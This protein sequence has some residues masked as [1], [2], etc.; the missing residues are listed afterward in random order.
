MCVFDLQRIIATT[1][2]SQVDFHASLKS[3]NDR[4]LELIKTGDDF[5]LLVLTNQQSAGRGQGNRNWVAGTGSLTFTLC[6]PGS[7]LAMPES[8]ALLLPLTVGL[9][10]CQ[11]IEAVAKLPNVQL[12]WPNDVMIGGKK[13]CGI[14]IEKAVGPSESVLT[15]GIGLNVNNEIDSKQILDNEASPA[16]HDTVPTSLRR[17]T[18]S[19]FDLNELLIRLVNQLFSQLEQLIA[20]PDEIVTRCSDRLILLNRSLEIDLPGGNILSGTC[21]GIGTSGELL[22]DSP[23]GRQA[24]FS[25]RVRFNP[26][27]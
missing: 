20:H 3:T 11:T 4:A 2:I 22:I 18:N 5:P 6:L 13:C 14:L 15:I 24:I 7:F 21:F 17:E 10:V 23:A 25:G 26:S 16:S 9:A 19:S 8:Q 27:S 12:K 1:A